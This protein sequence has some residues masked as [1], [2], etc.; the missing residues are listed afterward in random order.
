[1][2]CGNCGRRFTKIMLVEQTTSPD[3]N[4]KNVMDIQSLFNSSRNHECECPHCQKRA[5]IILYCTLL[6]GNLTQIDY[7]LTM[8]IN[9]KTK[10][11]KNV[12]IPS[13]PT[14]QADTDLIS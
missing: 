12:A 1:M 3:D 4:E 14:T 2:L 8:D 13:S 10:S 9:N 5:F 11:K 6:I 7:P